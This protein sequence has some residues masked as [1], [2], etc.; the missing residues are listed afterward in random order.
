[1]RT[2]EGTTG[3]KLRA[4]LFAVEL[5]KGKVISRIDYLLDI[6]RKMAEEVED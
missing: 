2:E 1:M 5:R 3:S 4:W 6:D